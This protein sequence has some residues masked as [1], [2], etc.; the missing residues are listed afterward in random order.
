M[1]NLLT[2]LMTRISASTLYSYVG[3]RVYLDAAPDGAQFPYVVFFIVSGNPEDTFKDKIDDTLIQFS[4]FSASTG[5][6]EITTMYANLKT[7]MDDAALTVTGDTQIWC[8]R[9]N[10]VTMTEDVIIADAAVRL[11]HWA[12]DYS[13]K[14]QD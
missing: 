13:I 4:L 2:G 11:K 3:G 12:V 14:V 9:Q 10:L 5:A 8:I 6:A 1:N 7:A